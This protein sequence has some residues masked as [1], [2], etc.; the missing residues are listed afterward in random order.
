MH[1]S[2]SSRASKPPL[3]SVDAFLKQ[4]E[5]LQDEILRLSTFCEK[6]TLKKSRSS[7]PDPDYWNSINLSLSKHGFNQIPAKLS[8]PFSIAD[9]LIDVLTEYSNLKQELKNVKISPKNEPVL[10]EKA[11][12]AQRS[13]YRRK[14]INEIVRDE[15]S[16]PYRLSLLDEV[17]QII[18]SKNYESIIPDLMKIKRAIVSLPNVEKFISFIC[19]ELIPEASGEDFLDLA[20]SRFKNLV[21]IQKEFEFVLQ[22]NSSL[23]QIVDYFSKLFKVQGLENVMDS[24]EC[25]FYFV[26]E[27][28]EFLDS[29]RKLLGLDPK[30]SPKLAIE[31]ILSKLN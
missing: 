18:E 2:K 7:K 30:S 31:V 1:S 26:H 27:M 17:K 25:V 8:S 16:E 3:A 20:I 19:S 10:N 22:E 4:S 29:S 21:K 28:K 13:S 5:E 15:L 11:G 23:K 24:I 14:S 12:R 9:V 6:E